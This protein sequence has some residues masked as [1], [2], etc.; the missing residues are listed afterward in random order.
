MILKVIEK[1]NKERKLSVP[2]E[3][4]LLLRLYLA[5]EELKEI[6]RTLTNGDK[7]LFVI[8]SK[9]IFMSVQNMIGDRAPSE[10]AGSPHSNFVF[11]GL[12]KC[13]IC[14]SAMQT[15]SAHGN[16][17]KYHYY[18]CSAALRGKTCKSRRIP[19]GELDAWL[20]DAIMDRILTHARLAEFI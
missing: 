12:L 4:D 17:G 20:I 11:T 9:E 1:G 16:G 10:G 8:I 18:N 13:G 3:A 14:G 6:D 19:A 7:V 5:H 15:E 2:P